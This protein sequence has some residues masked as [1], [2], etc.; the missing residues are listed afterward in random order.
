MNDEMIKLA[1]KTELAFEDWANENGLDLSQSFFSQ[2]KNRYTDPETSLAYEAWRISW[3]KAK[4]E[5][6]EKDAKIVIDFE[7]AC[8]D[9][10]SKQIAEAIRRGDVDN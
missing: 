3:N 2:L 5:Q 6:R 4:Q 7:T 10:C 1:E 9:E 8:C